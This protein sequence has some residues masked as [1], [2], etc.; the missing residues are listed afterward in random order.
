MVKLKVALCLNQYHVMK[1]SPLFNL[2]PCHDDVSAL[3]G[4]ERSRGKSFQYPP[5]GYPD[6]TCLGKVPRKN[7][8]G[9][10]SPVKY[11]KQR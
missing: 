9:K 10:D 6:K 4:G 2:T 3:D 11:V 5:T 8:F 7:V 1:K